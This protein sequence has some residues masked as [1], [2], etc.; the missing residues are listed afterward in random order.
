M[1]LYFS[2]EE[3]EFVSLC[4]KNTQ[5]ESS[6]IFE[7]IYHAFVHLFNQS[8]NPELKATEVVHK[9]K[10]EY[11]DK[12]LTLDDYIN[13]GQ[14][15]FPYPKVVICSGKEKIIYVDEV[16]L[17]KFILQDTFSYIGGVKKK[18]TV[19]QSKLKTKNKTSITFLTLIIT[20]DILK[21]IK[22]LSEKQTNN[23]LLPS[24]L[25]VW[26]WRQTFY[27]KIN[28]KSYFCDCFKEALQ[29]TSLKPNKKDHK[30]IQYALDNQKFKNGICHICSKTNSDL[31]Y[32]SKM[33]GSEVMVRYGAYI[34]KIAIEKETGKREA[35]N[36]IREH[37]GVAKIGEKWVNETLLFNYIN[38]IF[39][40][41]NVIREA[42]P[43]WLDRQR[44]DIFIPELDLAIEYQGQQH[45]E[46][47]EIFGGKEGLIKA[48]ERDKEKFSKCKKN[49]I[50]LLYFTYKENLS[51]KLVL[52]KIKKYLPKKN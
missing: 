52:K 12:H 46:P 32:C 49:N 17:P 29:K 50:K 2:F 34:E 3:D 16:W 33:Y 24:Q 45:F 14:I 44:L 18:I 13:L 37:L 36:I 43:T 27:N 40:Q 48:K 22:A 51:E 38:I 21:K 31:L 6:T 41:Y 30:H 19:K 42:S 28:G 1:P 11:Y 5:R 7:D 20:K 47:I 9:Y 25:G 8:I 26:E 10:T 35:E 23:N 39:P 4:A 15:E